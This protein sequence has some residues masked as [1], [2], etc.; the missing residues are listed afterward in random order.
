MSCGAIKEGIKFLV[1]G[2]G[3]PL[4][5]IAFDRG[6]P[7]L[8]VEIGLDIKGVRRAFIHDD[9]IGA[10]DLKTTEITH[11]YRFT[12]WAPIAIGLYATRVNCFLLVIE[13]LKLRRCCI[14]E[15]K[16]LI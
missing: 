10:G 1:N 8:L 5:I 9:L 3:G 12:R 14:C 6:M 13:Q 16:L 11:I 4:K 2:K 7:G 15:D